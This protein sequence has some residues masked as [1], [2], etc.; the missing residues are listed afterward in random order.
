MTQQGKITVVHILIIF[1]FLIAIWKMKN[2]GTDGNR[3]SLNNA[4]L[5]TL[6]FCS[7]QCWSNMSHRGV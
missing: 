5:H 6:M 1:F 7:K 3:D 4:E 2:F